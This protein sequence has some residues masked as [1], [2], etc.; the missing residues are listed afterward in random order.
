M[1]GNKEPRERYQLRLS[2]EE[3]EL[4]HFVMERE[5]ISVMSKAIRYCV[6]EKAKQIKQREKRW[7]NGK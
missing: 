7:S 6:Q 3:R 4:I 5:G 1:V 2:I